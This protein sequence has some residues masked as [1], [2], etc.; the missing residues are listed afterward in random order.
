MTDSSYRKLCGHCGEK[1]AARTYREHVRLYYDAVTQS[2]RKKRKHDDELAA[3]DVPL[4]SQNVDEGQNV[5]INEVSV[6]Q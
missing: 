2:W 1:L 3:V 4:A 6:S 5:I